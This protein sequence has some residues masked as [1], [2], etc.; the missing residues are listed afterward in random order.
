MLQYSADNR[1]NLIFIKGATNI[2]G[3]FNDD[4]I[5]KTLKDL[6]D[7]AAVKIPVYDT[8]NYT[9]KWVLRIIYSMPPDICDPLFTF[10]QIAS[11]TINLH[12]K[13]MYWLSRSF[14]SF[15]FIQVI[16]QGNAQYDMGAGGSGGGAWWVES[17]MIG[18]FK[19]CKFWSGEKRDY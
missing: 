10:V 5:L 16:L 1:Q 11:V 8:I 2:L 6:K 3:A 7:G 14:Y 4:L 12:H 17:E 13:D 19:I 18:I 9:F 15:T